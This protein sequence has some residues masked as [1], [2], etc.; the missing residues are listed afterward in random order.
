MI[1]IER[2]T[3]VKKS[4]ITTQLAAHLNII[5]IVTT[6]AIQKIIRSILSTELMPTLHTSSF[7][8]DTTLQK[9]PT[10]ASKP[11]II[12][13]QKQTATMSININTL[14]ERAAMENTN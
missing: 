4:T 10:T 2:T 13:F 3:N 6:N 12:K 1:L 7:Q 5:Q 11:L 14:I 8:A 9:P